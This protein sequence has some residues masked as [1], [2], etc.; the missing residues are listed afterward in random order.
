MVDGM[1]AET[2]FD[3]ASLILTHPVV[4]PLRDLGYTVTERAVTERI[5]PS[6]RIPCL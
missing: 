2:K 3:P 5:T 1:A 4:R 6:Q